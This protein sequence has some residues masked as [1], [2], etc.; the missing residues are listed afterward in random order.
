M[1]EPND[2]QLE[3]LLAALIMVLSAFT[4]YI[5]AGG[6]MGAPVDALRTK[7]IT[8]PFLR[9]HLPDSSQSIIFKLK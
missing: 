7:M 3:Y 8:R 5:A 1:K 9:K 6:Y 4:I 2:T